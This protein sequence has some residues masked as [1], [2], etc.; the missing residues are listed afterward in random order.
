MFMTKL[1]AAT[2]S[3]KKLSLNGTKLTSVD[4]TYIKPGTTPFY[5][6]K[7][8]MENVTVTSVFRS[9]DQRAECHPYCNVSLAPQRIAWQQILQK[10]DG[11]TG[12]KTTYGW[13]VTNNV[14]W[15]YVL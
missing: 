4:V 10:S 5:L 13:D 11:I 14:E 1:S 8:H 2:I 9:Q 6:L 7:I 15:A 12:A 3:F